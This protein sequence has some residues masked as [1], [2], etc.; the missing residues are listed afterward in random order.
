MSGEVLIAQRPEGKV[1]AGQW[2]FPGGKI[3]PGE[4][5][6]QALAREL[7]EELGIVVRASRP[8]IKVTHDYRERTVLLDCWRISAWDGLPQGREGQALA[9]VR[10]ERIADYPI[11]AADAPIVSALCLPAQYVF[12]PPR[13]AVGALLA[14]IATLPR[15][16]LLRLRLPALSDADYA[17]VA[18]EA[19][20]AA[21]DPALRVVLDRDPSLVV[22]LGAAGWHADSAR[23]RAMKERPPLPL[24]LASAHSPEELRRAQALGVD[25]AVLGPVRPT[26]SHPGAAF[27]GFETAADWTQRASLPIYWLGGLVPADLDAVQACYAQG[28]AAIGAYWS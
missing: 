19:I 12:T 2:E 5:A 8:L 15:G 21:R 9:W 14:R 18:A 1:A 11:L 3:E 28:I 17:A 25:A 22:R 13:I 23:L 10:P 26:A 16:A 20:A 7:H 24:C 4:S 6:R 27:L